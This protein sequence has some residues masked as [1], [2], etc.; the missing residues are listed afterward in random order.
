MRTDFTDP[1]IIQK[2]KTA[3]EPV[4]LLQLDWPAL[5]GLPALTLRLTDRE[6]VVINS[7]P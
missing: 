3:H 1:F 4:T 6:G 2:D 7:V 5:N